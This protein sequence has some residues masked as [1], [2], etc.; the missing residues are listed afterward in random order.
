[1]YVQ[2]QDFRD[3]TWVLVS[4]KNVRVLNMVMQCIGIVLSYLIAFFP[5]LFANCL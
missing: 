4:P 3:F 2:A 1:M 5:L